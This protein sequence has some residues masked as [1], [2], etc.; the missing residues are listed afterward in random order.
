[1]PLL[2]VPVPLQAA[3]AANR[4]VSGDTDEDEASGGEGVL[5][6]GQQEGCSICLLSGSSQGGGAAVTAGCAVLRAEP[7]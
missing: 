6:D 5:C 1:M 3:E 4:E 7:C 2:A